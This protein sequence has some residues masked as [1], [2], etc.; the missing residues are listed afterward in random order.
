MLTNNQIAA[1]VSAPKR[2]TDRK[3]TVGYRIDRGNQ[4]CDLELESVSDPKQRFAV[5]VRQNLEFVENFSVGLMFHSDHPRLKTFQLIRY[6]GPHGESSF[7]DDGHYSHPHIHYM[8]EVELSRGH[9]RPE[10]RL[11]ELTNR[12]AT[13]EQ[14]L[15]CFFTDTSVEDYLHYF[16]NLAQG[17]MLDES[18]FN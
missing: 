3:P 12:F 9:S 5:F 11:R 16:P 4:R 18:D 6:N 15:I 1:L 13:F 2:I 10:P 14:A 7:D 8:R 17:K